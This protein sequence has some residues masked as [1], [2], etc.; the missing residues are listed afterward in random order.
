MTDI[1]LPDPEP[2]YQVSGEAC[3]PTSA[4][5]FD[6]PHSWRDWPADGPPIVATQAALM[7]SWDAWVDEIWTAAVDGKAPVLSARFHRAYI[8]ANRARDDIDAGMLAESWAEAR[9]S[10]K[11]H[12]GFGLLRRHVLPGVPLYGHLLPLSDVQHRIARCYDP[13][14]A[15]VAGLIDAA[16]AHHPQAVHINCH[17]MKSIGNAMNEDEGLPRP[18]FVVSDLDGKCADPR[19]T[20]WIAGCLGWLG[21]RV[22]INHPYRGGELIRRHGDP[23]RGR[24]SLQIEINRALYMNEQAFE[25][26]EGL[27]RL[28]A[29][30]KTF[31]DQLNHQLQIGL[32]S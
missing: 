20:R 26:T 21:Y 17:S 23:A 31:V 7:T 12:R 28:V 29:D 8:D 30:L 16:R 10:D 1:P 22:R 25:R 18:D 4:L 3:A 27:A 6:S 14:H 15:K 19:L 13:Y 11:S 32:A 9:P 2:P 24:H 5:V